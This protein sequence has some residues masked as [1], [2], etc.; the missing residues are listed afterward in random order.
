MDAMLAFNG[1]TWIVRAWELR[2]SPLGE[3]EGEVRFALKADAV[4]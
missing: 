3:D 4:G 2:G 1:R